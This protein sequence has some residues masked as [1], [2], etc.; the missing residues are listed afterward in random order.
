MDSEL[1]EYSIFNNNVHFLGV[2]ALIMIMVFLVQVFSLYDLMTSIFKPQYDKTV[3]LMAILM[4]PAVGAALYILIRSRLKL[5][6]GEDHN[7][8]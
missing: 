7:L 5:S 2:T 6:S 4:F 8:L 3:W 1:I